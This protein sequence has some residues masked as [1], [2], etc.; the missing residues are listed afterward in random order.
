MNF[1]GRR[2]VFS[3][4][5]LGVIVSFLLTQPHLLRGFLGVTGHL[6]SYLPDSLAKFLRGQ[7]YL[8]F[9]FVWTMIFLGL[10]AWLVRGD[11]FRAESSPRREQFDLIDEDPDEND[12]E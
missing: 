3:G 4:I 12:R 2:L 6:Y 9:V 10:I 5:A 1:S 7:T 8:G 11:F